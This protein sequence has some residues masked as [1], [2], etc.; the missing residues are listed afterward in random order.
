MMDL[1]SDV[2][3]FLKELFSGGCDGPSA[4][5]SSGRLSCVST[6][7]P[8]SRKRFHHPLKLLA[9][10]FCYGFIPRQSAVAPLEEILFPG[11]V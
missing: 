10:R 5:Y 9:H 8:P 11:A 1:N 7:K 6:G 4:A 2:L 3:C